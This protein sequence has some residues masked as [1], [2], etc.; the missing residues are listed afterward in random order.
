MPGNDAE[1]PVSAG[2]PPI[3]GRDARILILGSLPSVRS[4]AVRQYY[5]HPKNAFWAIMRDIAG[6]D[7]SYA[8]RCKAL[9]AARIAVWDVLRHSVRPGSRDA[10]IRLDTS[11]A[12]DF[13]GF[14][15]EH[16]SIGRILFNGRTA[17]RLFHRL[18]LVGEQM[19]VPDLV[20]LPSTS[21]AHA[22]MPLA[23]KLARWRRA[24]L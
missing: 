21:P 17:E 19:P 12:N 8:E 2:F 14:L 5:A 10:D 20:S 11:E 18:V 13:R 24:I 3:A 22:A 6:A 4:L 1:M 9:L 16:P 15:R 7:G 23:E